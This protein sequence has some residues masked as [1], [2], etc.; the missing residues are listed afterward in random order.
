MC[1][2]GSDIA[3]SHSVVLNSVPRTAL[4]E[5]L[6]VISNSLSTSYSLHTAVPQTAQ[7]GEALLS[8]QGLINGSMVKQQILLK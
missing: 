4:S 2:F 1:Y 8:E 6:Q 5:W 7:A 3:V